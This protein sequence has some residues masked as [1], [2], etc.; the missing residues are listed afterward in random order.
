M[1][2]DSVGAAA[3]RCPPYIRIPT[4]YTPINKLISVSL[5]IFDSDNAVQKRCGLFLVAII[6]M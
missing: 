1:L 6:L 2:P 3:Q 5:N 4:H